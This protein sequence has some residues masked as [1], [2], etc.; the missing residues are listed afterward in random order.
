[1]SLFTHLI[2]YYLLLSLELYCSLAYNPRMWL[3]RMPP[4]EIAKVP[5]R[6]PSEKRLLLN[7]LSG[8]KGVVIAIAASLALATILFFIKVSL[9]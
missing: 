8:V 9:A 5:K 2:L 3:H 4:E 6:T 1:M 7:L